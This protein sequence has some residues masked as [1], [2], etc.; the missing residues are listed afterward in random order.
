VWA[1]RLVRRHGGVL[2][3]IKAVNPR[4]FKG[5]MTQVGLLLT[6]ATW[7]RRRLLVP[8]LGTLVTMPPLLLWPIPVSLTLLAFAAAQSIA[9]HAGRGRRLPD[10]RRA[11]RSWAVGLSVWTW[12]R[13][14]HAYA[15]IAWWQWALVW[16][17]IVTW[18]AVRWGRAKLLAPAPSTAMETVPVCAQ[19][20]AAVVAEM[21][22]EA[23]PLAWC[24]IRQLAV[25]A[26]RVAS[27]VVALG[28]GQHA[29]SAATPSL[30]LELEAR[31]R[32]P[33]GGAQLE[34]I[35][36]NTLRI[37][38]SWSLQLDQEILTW[39]PNAAPPGQAWIGVSDDRRDILIPAWT[40]GADG[41]VSVHHGWV[42]GR[43]GAGKSVTLTAIV[44]PG[45][46]L[47]LELVLVVDGKGDSLGLIEPHCLRYARLDRL[48]MEQVITL[49]WAIMRS[50][51][52]RLQSGDPWVGP[53]PTDPLITLVI[54][55]CTTVRDMIAVE[56]QRM[57]DEMGRM[58]RS[59][60]LRTIQSGQVPTVDS[61]IG[62]ASWRAQARWIIGHA[63]GDAVHSRVATQSTAQE[64]SL[65]GLPV[66]RAVVLM[67]GELV[68]GRARITLVTPEALAAAMSGVEPAVL[69][70]TDA[71]AVKPLW[72]LTAGWTA[73]TIAAPP[74]AA[75]AA[76]NLD[77]HLARWEPKAKGTPVEPAATAGAA[78]DS[79]A[80]DSG[81][82]P[83][84]PALRL[85][86]AK[87]ARSWLLG[88]LSAHGKASGPEL[89][90]AA[91]GAYSRSAVYDALRGLTEAGSVVRDGD[92]YATRASLVRRPPA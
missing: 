70:P 22:A 25:P 18:A 62:Q 86:T 54:D 45:L 27:A 35:D 59:L 91:E 78:D 13:T 66:G 44:L 10:E 11:A 24:Q 58:G 8:P 90:A 30:R 43:T 41:K 84:P 72:D 56:Y 40:A 81:K 23:G 88:W 31:L 2:P 82:H 21:S 42:I 6:A 87:T 75:P 26:T 74:E 63:V 52:A 33:R 48:R 60:G 64:I 65:L 9:L 4:T 1:I 5:L 89:V 34:V 46:T 51:Q 50:R 61:L 53:S 29:E 76:I 17:V 28:Y 67:D 83:A 77:G 16:L 15:G 3:A 57:V 71:A 55:E 32:C 47:A 14:S 68:S 79:A 92:Q 38:A 80:A 73:A 12:A 85:V 49:A 37:T 39:R 36:A 19:A 69:H 7:R 20:L